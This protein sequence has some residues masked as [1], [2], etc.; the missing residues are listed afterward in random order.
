MATPV[1]PSSINSAFAT[2]RPGDR[3]VLAPGN[4]APLAPPPNLYLS[5]DAALPRPV[6]ASFTLRG[7]AQIMGIDVD[8][9]GIRNAILAIDGLNGANLS[10]MTLRN[11]D[12]AAV[13]SQTNGAK[14]PNTDIILQDI[15]ATNGKSMGP[16][17]GQTFGVT[18]LRCWFDKIGLGLGSSYHG[19]YLNPDNCSSSRSTDLW[20]TRCATG[21]RGLTDE[22][23]RLL[24]ADSEGAGIAASCNVTRMIRPISMNNGGD[25]LRI[26]PR[27][28]MLIESP[29]LIG[30]DLPGQHAIDIEGSHTPRYDSPTVIEL[31]YLQIDGGL[32]YRFPSNADNRG[33][34]WNIRV[35]AGDSHG[36]GGADINNFTTASSVNGS[37][38]T[39]RTNISWGDD[40][41]RAMYRFR[42]HHETT[43]AAL[44]VPDKN[45]SLL[46]YAASQ[47]L[48][49]TYEALFA[50]NFSMADAHQHIMD[51]FGL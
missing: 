10:H 27:N 18:M 14:K 4:Y 40:V 29:L 24:V 49:P 46:T 30:H 19:L 11:F 15:K 5:S 26:D 32:A 23:V 3:L 47:G 42:N 7:N 6:V 37:A 48:A 44:V 41:N 39:G 36:N 43:D 28:P 1:T 20:F 13:F 17:F 2:A 21:T 25:A 38:Q 51:G 45:A 8:G 31:P 9:G 34:T 35:N 22:S 33:T 16:L 50:A 12:G